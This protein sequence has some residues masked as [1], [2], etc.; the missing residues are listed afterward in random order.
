MEII[1]A[2]LNGSSN[3]FPGASYGTGVKCLHPL[4]LWVHKVQGGAG[5]GL[6]GIIRNQTRGQ[7]LG[8]V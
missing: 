3:A 4:H 2:G 8:G 1:S 5:L 6:P 7:S